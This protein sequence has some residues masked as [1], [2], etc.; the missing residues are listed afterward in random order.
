MKESTRIHKEAK[1]IKA[2]E[3]IFGLYGFKNARMEQVASEADITKVTL[4]SYFRSKENLYMAITHNAIGKLVERYENT[5]E[6]TSAQ[7]GI[8]TVLALIEE[9]MN[10]CHENYLYS[11][12]FLDYFSLIRSITGEDDIKLT[13]AVKESTFFPKVQAIHN[14]PFKITAQQIQRG[15]ADGSISKNIDPMVGTLYGWTAAIGFVKISIASGHGTKSNT[16]FNVKLSDLRKNS[17]EIQRRLLMG[18]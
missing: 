2:A 10:F 8:E 7:S 9:F 14:K 13:E 6:K 16:L 1:I 5:V 15:I 3:K 12:V 17:L 4:Y 11:E 18:I